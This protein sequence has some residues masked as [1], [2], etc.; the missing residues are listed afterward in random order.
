M[1][2]LKCRFE[3]EIQSSKAAAAAALA[4]AASAG[5]SNAPKMIIGAGTYSQ[6]QAQMVASRTGDHSIAVAGK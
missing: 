6:V 1:L 2:L 3:E 5:E 4:V